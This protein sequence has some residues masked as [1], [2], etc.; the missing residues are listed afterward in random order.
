MNMLTLIVPLK[1]RSAYT[2]RLMSHLNA[3]EFPYPVLLADGGNDTG[4]QN[5][6]NDTSNYPNISYEYCRYPY[7]DSITTYHKKMANVVD[8][9]STP[10]S[11]T[12]DND[13]F[14]VTEGLNKAI[15]FLQNNPTYSSARGALTGFETNHYPNQHERKGNMYDLYPEDI[16]GATSLER[17]IMQSNNWHGNWHPVLRTNHFIATNKIIAEVNPSNFRFT[18]QLMGFLNILWGN[19]NRDTYDFVLHQHNSPRI[20]GCANDFPNQ[21][22]WIQNDSWS[23]NFASMTDGIA[24]GISICDKVSIDSAREKFRQ[25]YEQMYSK[26]VPNNID[27]LKDKIQK[28][29]HF[30]RNLNPLKHSIENIVND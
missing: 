4:L 11:V 17:V 28:S 8:K 23:C 5:H 19:G 9:I 6:L 27:L 14:V 12:I 13:D 1:N 7:D 26:R 16:T 20:E 29:T 22:T 25:C 21:N 18:E 30:Y 15:E 24:I 3:I 2:Y 10:F